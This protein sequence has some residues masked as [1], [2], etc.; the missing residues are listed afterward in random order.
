[1]N[2]VTYFKHSREV[3]GHPIIEIGFFDHTRETCVV[4]MHMSNGTLT[5]FVWPSHTGKFPPSDFEVTS[6]A[7]VAE[8]FAEAVRKFIPTVILKPVI[9]ILARAQHSHTCAECGVGFTP[10]HTKA[11]YCTPACKARAFR[12]RSGGRP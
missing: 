6:E 3:G 9:E 11:I 2:G 10:L 4:K 12:S 7:R 8:A 5:P 1:M